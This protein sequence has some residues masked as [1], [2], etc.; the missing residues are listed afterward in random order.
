MLWSAKRWKLQK[1]INAYKDFAFKYKQSIYSEIA[2]YYYS[3]GRGLLSKDILLD[4]DFIN[5]CQWFL[6]EFPNSNYSGSVVWFEAYSIAKVRNNKYMIKD[7]LEGV[8][9]NHPN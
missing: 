2:F 5:D 8:I 4:E 6:N 9:E 3:M 7:F 1:K